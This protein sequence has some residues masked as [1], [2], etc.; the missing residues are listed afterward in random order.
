MVSQFVFIR[1]DANIIDLTLDLKTKVLFGFLSAGLSAG[2]SAI[3]VGVYDLGVVGLTLGFIIGQLI[4]SI[5]YPLIV[6]RFFRVSLYAQL[7][8]LLRPAL[9]TILL[10][11][12]LTLFGDGIVV[13]S[14]FS[15]LLAAGITV[16]SLSVLAFYLGVTSEQRK[17][18]LARV[19]K[20][21]PI[22]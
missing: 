21:L 18:L 9:V 2:I 12:S 11:G 6:G 13:S 14:W 1:N 8:G 7:R 15:L 5:G 22:Q 19:R 4:L 17:G 20:L 10:F 16:G 3:L